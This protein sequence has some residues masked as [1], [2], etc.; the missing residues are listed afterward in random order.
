MNQQ[1]LP[2]P[3]RAVQYNGAMVGLLQLSARIFTPGH[4]S[5]RGNHALACRS[6]GQ[7]STCCIY[8]LPPWQQQAFPSLAVSISIPG[9]KLPGFLSTASSQA[10]LLGLLLQLPCSLLL[11]PQ[12]VPQTVLLSPVLEGSWNSLL[13]G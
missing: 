7:S 4:P 3:L 8:C 1:F 13:A 2:L 12:P 9:P 6:P 10:A 5:R 11:P